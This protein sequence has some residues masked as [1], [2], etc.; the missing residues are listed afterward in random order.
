MKHCLPNKFFD[1]IQARLPVAIGPSPEMRGLIKKYD[2]G[3]VAKEFTVESMAKTLNNL[4]I[5]EIDIIKKNSEGVAKEFCW[6]KESLKLNSI[7]NH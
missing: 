5:S 2:C 7:F 4:S 1:F 3:F 6:E